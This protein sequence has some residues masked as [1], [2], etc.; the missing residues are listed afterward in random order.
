MS[1]AGRLESRAVR[2]TL[3]ALVVV[4][5]AVV[6]LVAIGSIP[7][8]MWYDEAIYALDGLSIGRGNWPIF[9]ATEMHPREP[10]YIYYLGGFFAAFG[11]SVAKARVAT[12]LWGIATVALF[13]PVARR[14]L[15]GAGWA[16][17][18]AFAFAAFRWHVH[19]SR[20]VF[21]ALLPSFFILAVV[22]FFLRWRERRRP[23]DAVLCGASLGAGMYTYLSFRLVPVLMAAWV[24]WLLARGVLNLRRDWRGLAL[25]AVTALVVF[26]PL[27]VDYIR[28]P[29]HF[30]GRTDEVSMF[31]KR[32]EPAPGA[33]GAT[34][35]RKPATEVL[36]DLGANARDIALMWTWRGDHVGKHNLPHAPVFDW[37]T[38][39]LFFAG[40]AWCV[41][42]IA[43]REEA[44]LVLAWLGLMSLTSV[45]SFGA[46]N[47]LRMQGATPAAI[48]CMMLGMRW[49]D[50]ALA[51][52]VG[53]RVRWAIPALVLSVFAVLQLDTYFRRFPRS[54]AVRREFNTESFHD[55]A[56]LVL[57]KAASAA[58]VWVPVE[59]RRHPTF[60]FVTYG[61]A[62][63]R[64]YGPSDDVPTTGARSAALLS[65]HRSQM[66]ASENGRDPAAAW[67]GAGARRAGFTEIVVEDPATGNAR[68]M[69]WSELWVLDGPR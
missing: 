67:R 36:R 14:L 56:R 18:A 48:L 66:L 44:F 2:M 61:M 33:G 49:F 59:M 29:W 4:F 8:G 51:V 63:L 53:P 32:V 52:R 38:G 62:G 16:L 25:I 57:D 60:D 6:R 43:R 1:G 21:R 65:T 39:L 35:V 30:H 64:E 45:F 20:T 27:G 10:L 68:L 19:F 47:I 50:T 55:P 28:N 54:E 7:P 34:T 26:A 58:E 37:A 12:A 69:L 41:W 11:H 46:P 42:N 9:F 40:L 15:G 13:Y 3:L 24:A 5:A 22:L 23:L 17:A 31:V